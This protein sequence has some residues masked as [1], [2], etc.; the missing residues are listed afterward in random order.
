MKQKLWPTAHLGILALVFA[1]APVR[2]PR[3]GAV[4]CNNNAIDD[5]EDV[6]ARTSADCSGNNVSDECEN[7]GDGD[8]DHDVD[9]AD[10]MALQTCLGPNAAVEAGCR[11]FD[12]DGDGDTDLADFLA[13]TARFTGPH[14]RRTIMALITAA[15][16]SATTLIAT[17]R[18]TSAR[19]FGMSM[20]ERPAATTVRAGPMHS[21][22]C[23]L[24]SM[25]PPLP[26]DASLRFGWPQ[27]CIGPIAAREIGRR[28]LN[29]KAA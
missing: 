16:A 25:R 28:H 23:R 10:V 14:M 18:R 22:T 26:I 24:P 7:V 20:L 19:S 13:L 11:A 17:A 1:I 4:D 5:A 9:L 29:S 27:A 12:L 21:P 2:T 8:G 6:A 3:A 15:P